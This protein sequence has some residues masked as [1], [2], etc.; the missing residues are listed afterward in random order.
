[1]TADAP[2]KLRT[3]KVAAWD[4]STFI[5]GIAHDFKTPLATISTSAELLANNVEPD[6][7]DRLVQIIQREVGRLNTMV[8]DLSDYFSFEAGGIDLH[9]EP[10]DIAALVREHCQQF[11]ESTSRHSLDLLLPATPLIIEADAV[12]VLRIIDNLLRNAVL[13]TPG[14][15]RIIVSVRHESAGTGSVVLSVTDEGPGIPE[16]DRTTIF[17][18]FV[19]LEGTERK[20]QGLGLHVVRQLAELH[21]GA[22]WV[23]S[24][25]GG[26]ARF[27]VRLP[28]VSILATGLRH[29]A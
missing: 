1:L 17:D 7:S 24:G 13:Y 11:Q 12:K 6:L 10:V 18:P 16:E 22:A 26:G 28:A 29:H 8:Q 14:D 3:Q 23:E 5:A 27:C 25:R 19:R 2:R 15:T 9:P 4:K 21:G 20:G